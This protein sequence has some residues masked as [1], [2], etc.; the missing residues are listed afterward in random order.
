M[1]KRTL[2]FCMCLT[3]LFFFTNHYFTSKKLEEKKYTLEQVELKKKKTLELLKKDAKIK[4]ASLTDL[5]VTPLYQEKENQNVAC[6]GVNIGSQILTLSW[7]TDL[8]KILYDQKQKVDLQFNNSSLIEPVLYSHQAEKLSL[9]NISDQEGAEYQLLSM[10]SSPRVIFAKIIDTEIHTSEVLHHDAIAFIKTPTTYVPVGIFDGKKNIV[11]P[12]KEYLQFQNIVQIE[13]ATSAAREE[14]FYVLENEYQMLVF[15]SKGGALAEINLPFESPKNPK[16]V[17][18]EINFDRDML[19]N[20]PENDHFPQFPYSTV[21]N[22]SM[23]SHNRGELGGYYPLLRRSIFTP[24]G[25]VRH[26]V[27]SEY[28]AFNILGDDVENTHFEVKRFEKNLIEFETSSPHRRITKT[29]SLPQNSNESPYTIDV[30]IKME[31][32]ARELWLG[33]GI[34]EVELISGSFTPAL[35]YRVT[36]GQKSQVEKLSLPQDKPSK[37]TLL[38]TSTLP[39]WISNSNGFLGSIMDPLNEIAAGFKAKVIPGSD[40]P[41]RLSLIDAHYNLYPVTKYPGYETYLPLRSNQV[42]EF[43]TFAGPFQDDILKTIDVTYSDPAKHYNPDYIA[44]QSFHGWF[45]FISEPFAKFLFILMKFFHTLTGSWGFSIILLTVVLRIM[46]YPLNAWSIKSSA[47]MQQIN[48]EIKKI[49]ERYKKDPQKAKIETMK[50]YKEKGANPF[51]GCF[52]LLIQMPFLIGMFDLLKST[53]ELRGAVFIPG[54]INNLTAPDVL[55]SWN[56]PIFFL[57]TNFHLLP[58]L[59]GLTM[60]AQQKFTAYLSGNTGNA[61]KE[62]LSDQQKQQKVMGNV[63]VI[64]FTVLFYHFPSGLN[65]YWLSSMVLGIFQQWIMKRKLTPPSTPVTTV[66]LKRKK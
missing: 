9:V 25:E 31:G 56:Y 53:F 61:G 6:Y 36:R 42:M 41:T 23:V 5:S 29:F 3:T 60:Y 64:V 2:F 24:Q 52:P 19:K 43:R 54:W 58:I 20:H 11:R 4:T 12:L 45:S 47:R 37:D 27:P 66:Q 10:E 39:D 21:Q 14:S 51:M 22:G 48:P 49:Q 17:V 1:D 57:G 30:R 15:S 7:Q 50:L 40:C 18:K 44:A 28:Y 65:I 16:S 38:V 46:L 55:F 35:K 59:L 26:K 63:M 33:S 13:T 34:P 8:P 32:D 62:E